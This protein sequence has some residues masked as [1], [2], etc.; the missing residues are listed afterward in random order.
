MTDLY[1]E[2]PRRKRAAYTLV[3]VFFLAGCIALV[4]SAQGIGPSAI[5]QATVLATSAAAVF[6][7]VRY[8]LTSRAYRLTYLGGRRVLLVE[9]KQGKRIS[10]A[11]Y[12]YLDR[13]EHLFFEQKDEK[14]L[15]LSHTPPEGFSV[16]KRFRYGNGIG[17]GERAVIYATHD[18][19][20]VRVHL[21]ASRDFYLALEQSIA[22]A[23]IDI[24]THGAYGD[25]DEE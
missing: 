24:A 12:L 6:V 14:G 16:E 1:Y 13:T 17:K 25:E 3:L 18:L 21:D 9:E 10:C 5:W 2:P 7:A 20:R 22:Q 4:L 11:F 8:L 15:L 23:K 19:G